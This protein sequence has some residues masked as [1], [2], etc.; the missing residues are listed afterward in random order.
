MKHIAGI[1]SKYRLFFLLGL[2]F[3]LAGCATSVSSSGPKPFSFNFMSYTTKSF[4]TD[5]FGLVYSPDQGYVWLLINGSVTNNQKSDDCLNWIYDSF[6]FVDQNKNN[7]SLRLALNSIPGYLP[8]CYNPQQTKSG[9]LV[10]EIPIGSDP[11]KGTLTIDLAG[12]L[13]G[14]SQSETIDMSTLVSY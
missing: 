6:V 8:T 11:A 1:W 4:L 9:F 7:H 12:F 3:V 10:F 13:H 14:S 5:G 2:V